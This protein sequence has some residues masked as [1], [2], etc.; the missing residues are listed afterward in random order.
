MHSRIK[1]I[2]RALIK[3]YKTTDVYELAKCLDI[4]LIIKPLGGTCAG[5]YM[6]LRRSKIIFLNSILNEYERI[7]VLAHEIGHA[8]LHK[9]TNCY[10]MKSKT[11]FLTSKIEKEANFFAAEFLIKDDVLNNYKG[12]TLNQIAC[13][14]N[15][16]SDLLKLKFD[17]F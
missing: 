3:K 14:E 9:E 13:I 1:R 8:V 6:Y 4:T 5:S 10:F 16:S 12:Y 2:V 11:L 15:I 17:W 7:I